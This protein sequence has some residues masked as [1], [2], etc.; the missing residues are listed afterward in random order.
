MYPGKNHIIWNNDDFARDAYTVREMVTDHD[1]LKLVGP[2]SEV[3]S[4]R[5]HTYLVFT[6]PLYY[7]FLAPWYAISDGDPNLPVTMSI[8]AHMT[9]MIPLG[10]LSYKL[11]KNKV[12]VLI[13][14]LLFALSYEQIEYSRWLLNPVFALPFLSWV[15][16]FLWEV[17]KTKQKAFFLGLWIGMA[18][19]SEIFLGYWVVAVILVFVVTKQPLKQWINL[20]LGGITGV[21]PLLISE[22]KF[23]FRMT[24]SLLFDFLL[25]PMY[26]QDRSV[27]TILNQWSEHWGLVARNTIFGT[28]IQISGISLLLLI[29]L[30]VII[31]LKNKK[32]RNQL[33][34]IFVILFAPAIIFITNF[35]NKA[36]VDLGV[37][38]S[39]IFLSTYVLNYFW[40]RQKSIVVTFILFT[41][42]SQILLLIKNVEA[43]TPYDGYSFLPTE[44]ILFI[45]KLEIAE[46]IY[47][48]TKSDQFTISIM[49]PPYGFPAMWGSVFE[50]YSK[51]NNSQM[52]TWYGWYAHGTPGDHIFNVSD[53]PEKIHVVLRPITSN[54][55]QTAQAIFYQKQDELTKPY[56][57]IEKNN[58][59]I[60]FRKKIQ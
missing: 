9:S 58:Y 22:I 21:L 1:F 43:R 26:T 29:I 34:F 10:L 4:F 20:V 42:I 12:A 28:S 55:D 11:F 31:Y 3:Y 59:R 40:K 38:F 13:T 50:Q 53:H 30:A 8:L 24:D 37:G 23:G 46:T 2:R 32:E 33:H 41:C 17:L 15:Y 56:K 57:V 44:N 47:S 52:P 45:D 5:Y 6:G 19:Q 48:E 54:F 27:V 60:E 35:V 16:Y 18:I 7:Y 36:Y 39:F 14:L 51:N 25:L 49:D